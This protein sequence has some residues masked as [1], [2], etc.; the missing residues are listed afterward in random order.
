MAD[1]KFDEYL[2]KTELDNLET[3][4]V[5]TQTKKVSLYAFDTDTLEKKRVTGKETDGK[6]GL[7]IDNTKTSEEATLLRRLVK[8]ME[9]N[10][11]VDAAN[12]QR[13]IVEGTVYNLPSSYYA[14]ANQFNI[15]NSTVFAPLLN[16]SAT[17]VQPVQTGPVDP[18][19]QIID[20]TRL[21]FQQC[22]RGNLSFT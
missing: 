2:A 10:S 19:W 21:N 1:K 16:G 11:V 13:I 14:G 18:R 9:S 8:I 5:G 3:D 7:S 12:R 22:I 15:P 17:Y 4:G 20:Q 6:F